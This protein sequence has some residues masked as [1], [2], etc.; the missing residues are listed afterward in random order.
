MILNT[1]EN[2]Y[3]ETIPVRKGA[4]VDISKLEG[5]LK[6]KIP[7]LPNEPLVVEQFATGNSNLTY[8]VRI[9][10][11]EAVLRRAPAGPVNPK[12]HNMEREFNI[13]KEV[14]PV[15]PMAPKPYL[16]YDDNSIVGAPFYVMERRNG[17]LLEKVI[18]ESDDK[19]QLFQ[20][21]SQNMVETMASLHQI[22]YKDTGL[23]NMTRPE[24]FLER[25]VTNWIKR[26]DDVKTEDYSGVEQLKAWLIKHLPT[27]PSPS[28]I[29]YDFHFKNV[30]FNK[31]DNSK[32]VGV[33]DWELST[34]GDPLA[35]LAT[36]I[37]FWLEE[38][39]PIELKE[40]SGNPIT[41]KPGFYSRNQF[42][43]EYAKKSGRDV[44]NMNYYLTFA[45]FKN[46]VIAQ[47]IYYRYKRGY[48][49]DDRFINHHRRVRALLEM[50][51]KQI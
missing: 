3:S 49:Q 42:I 1:R 6:E 41:I 48:T 50:A 36:A 35:D 31:E 27:S 32:I 17:F 2:L 10:E 12:A 28:I 46:S 40:I 20:S 39:D 43:E 19:P 47:Q 9:G 21:I 30:M 14:N 45:Y 18:K 38:N 29:H 44:S 33:F 15:F 13:I 4:E 11:W 25:Q 34:V 23:V 5:F 37:I 7:S 8:L 24:G 26:Y 51:M 22:N 16:F